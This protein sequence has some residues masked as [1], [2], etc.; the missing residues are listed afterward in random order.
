MH[1]IPGSHTGAI[2]LSE[3]DE[4]LYIR[5]QT[6]ARLHVLPE[7]LTQHEIPS[8]FGCLRRAPGEYKCKQADDQPHQVRPC[9]PN[10]G[11]ENRASTL[12]IISLLAAEDAASFSL[13]GS[14]FLG[15]MPD[16]PC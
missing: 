15:G 13:A 7:G 12:R 1:E 3:R 2:A 6:S 9:R 11:S 14:R 16:L 8:L 5:G 10:A 4:C